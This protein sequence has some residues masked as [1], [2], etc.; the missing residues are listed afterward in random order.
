MNTTKEI[1][2]DY[3]LVDERRSK[4][5]KELTKLEDKLNFRL[6]IERGNEPELEINMNGKLFKLLLR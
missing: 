2:P 5:I 6:L 4:I 1:K 3:I